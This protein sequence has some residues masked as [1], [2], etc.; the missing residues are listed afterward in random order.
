LKEKAAK[1]RSV[2]EAKTPPHTSTSEIVQGVEE[3]LF[4]TKKLT[5]QT[6]NLLPF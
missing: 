5:L 4:N 2:A 6:R 1:A 3:R